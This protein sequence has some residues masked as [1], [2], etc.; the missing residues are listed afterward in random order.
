M[1]Q[2]EEEQWLRRQNGT[3]SK[4]QTLQPS[5]SITISFQEAWQIQFDPHSPEV[6]S[7]KWSYYFNFLFEN[8]IFK[9]T[10]PTQMDK[11]YTCSS[12]QTVNIL[13]TGLSSRCICGHA[14]ASY[15]GEDLLRQSDFCSISNAHPRSPLIQSISPRLSFSF[16]AFC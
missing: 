1:I 7:K 12:R 13:L 11:N 15:S 6:T 10:K 8:L 9:M 2:Q 3:R 4:R 5:M 14:C 16:F